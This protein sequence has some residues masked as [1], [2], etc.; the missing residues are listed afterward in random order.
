MIQVM[1]VMFLSD[2]KSQESQNKTK[3]HAYAQEISSAS[4]S[5]RN[6]RVRFLTKIMR[7]P[8]KSVP[9][10]CIPKEPH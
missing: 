5:N 8:P 1:K 6:G 2:T 10:T 7:N 9:G 3:R 4:I